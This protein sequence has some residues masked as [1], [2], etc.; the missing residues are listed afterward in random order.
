[1]IFHSLA[2]QYVAKEGKPIN[3]YIIPDLFHKHIKKIE[4][5]SNISL[6]IN[7]L[8]PL[9]AIVYFVSMS[10]LTSNS[11]A[12]WNWLFSISIVYFLRAILFS[13][14][15]LPDAS[16]QCNDNGLFGGCNDLLYS[17]HIA[18]T[19]IT[20]LYIYHFYLKDYRFKIFSLIYL[21]AM[22]FVILANR[23]H[24]TIDIILALLIPYFIFK[25]I[26]I[27]I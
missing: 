15:V 26:R 12:F 21:L 24:Y 19:T 23:N 14:T 7:D 20:L 10:Y 18:V 2:Q 22:S 13:V 6:I 8:F 4:F 25:S 5:D 17:G 3:D 16:K 27:K 11:L 1:M 9:I